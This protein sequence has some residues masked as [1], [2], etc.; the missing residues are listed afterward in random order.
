MAAAVDGG[1]VFICLS[2]EKKSWAWKVLLASKNRHLLWLWLTSTNQNS[3]FIVSAGLPFVLI[4][5]PLTRHNKCCSLLRF[6]LR[7][8]KLPQLTL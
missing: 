5:L 3:Q 2:P 7:E 6:I 1:G 4:I 8:S